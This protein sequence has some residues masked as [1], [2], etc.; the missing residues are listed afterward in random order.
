MTAL[1]DRAGAIADQLHDAS[2]AAGQIA[3]ARDDRPP[4]EPREGAG[5]DAEIAAAGG[6]Q[7]ALCAR[8]ARA[9]DAGL[10]G[11]ALRRQC[12]TIQILTLRVRRDVLSS[13]FAMLS[14]PGPE[15]PDMVARCGPDGQILTTSH[16]PT[17]T[18]IHGIFRELARPAL[19]PKASSDF[20]AA[21][22]RK[23]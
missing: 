1:T 7:D 21:M 2:V 18:A 6:M 16:A 17:V 8:S 13:P 3:D 22:A 23:P 14:C 19:S 12:V 9:T 20:I 10:D 4:D 5:S 15:D 11:P